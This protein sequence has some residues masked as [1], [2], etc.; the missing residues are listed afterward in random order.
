MPPWMVFDSKV[1]ILCDQFRLLIQLS[2]RGEVDGKKR[3]SAPTVYCALFQNVLIFCQA[4]FAAKDETS[5]PTPSDAGILGFVFLQNL[6]KTALTQNQSGEIRRMSSTSLSFVLILSGAKDSLT[7][8]FSSH[9]TELFQMWHE[10]LQH[11]LN[12]GVRT[13]DGDST[14]FVQVRF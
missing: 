14:A 11:C 2:G 12:S 4:T 5:P 7:F 9:S 13:N 10:T 6:K 3:T 8:M 1:P